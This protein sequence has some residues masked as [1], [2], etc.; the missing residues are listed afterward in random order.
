ME[1][2][3]HIKG[4]DKMKVSQDKLEKII[5][6]LADNYSYSAIADSVGVTR[7]TVEQISKKVRVDI[8]SIKEN[9]YKELYDRYHMNK[10]DRIQLYGKDLLKIERELS[11]RDLSDISDADLIELKQK[12]ISRL[13]KLFTPVNSEPVEKTTQGILDALDNLYTRIQNGEAVNGRLELQ[14]L[15][16]MADVINS[17]EVTKKLS[18]LSMAIDTNEKPQE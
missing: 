13:E 8:N 3:F 4:S 17:E 10:K 6:M 5:E 16:A 11:K 2:F 1:G 12:T 15:Q 18:I 14:V 9:E 7:Y